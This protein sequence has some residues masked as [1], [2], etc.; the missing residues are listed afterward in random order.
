MDS[1]A[2]LG[3]LVWDV[4]DEW[5]WLNAG[6]HRMIHREGECGPGPLK[7]IVG[8][9]KPSMDT[10]MGGLKLVALKLTWSFK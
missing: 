3:H 7:A 5:G 2:R 4:G 1:W 10:A 6:Q 8:S 9:S